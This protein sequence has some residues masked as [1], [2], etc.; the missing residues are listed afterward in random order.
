MLNTFAFSSR[1]CI[2]SLTQINQTVAQ[3]HRSWK[4]WQNICVV[5]MPSRGLSMFEAVRQCHCSSASWLRGVWWCKHVIWTCR[6]NSN[7]TGTKK[8]PYICI[9]ILNLTTNPP[10][11]PD[12]PSKWHNLLNIRSLLFRVKT[13]WTKHHVHVLQTVCAVVTWS[14]LISANLSGNPIKGEPSIL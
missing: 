9:N 6:Y 3:T 11:S 14:G 8:S 12:L 1:F 2:S 13:V 5:M 4:I 10:C 7:L